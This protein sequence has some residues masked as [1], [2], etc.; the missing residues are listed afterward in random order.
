M[1]PPADRADKNAILARRARFV[2]AA[3]AGMGMLASAQPAYA[4]G[5]GGTGGAAQGAAGPGGMGSGGTASGGGDTG[6]APEVCLSIAQPPQVCL[7]ACEQPGSDGPSGQSTAA[8]ALLALGL[9][10]SRRPRRK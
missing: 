7:C 2:A 3:V 4:E 1:T 5:G 9:A 6:G 10:A 8:I